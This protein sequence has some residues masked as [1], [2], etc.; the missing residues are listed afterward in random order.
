MP[1]RRAARALA[2]TNQETLERARD[3]S[4][5]L[6]R[7]DALVAQAAS[8]FQQCPKSR[9]PCRS[10]AYL[11]YVTR[12]CLDRRPAVGVRVDVRTDDDH[13]RCPFV[14]QLR[15]DRRRT[16]LN[17]GRA[18][19]LS[20][21]LGDPRKGDERQNPSRSFDDRRLTS[22]SVVATGNPR[23]GVGR[24]YSGDVNDD[25]EAVHNPARIDDTARTEP[26]GLV[27]GSL[28][29]FLGRLNTHV[30]PLDHAR[31]QHAALRDVAAVPLI[32]EGSA[33]RAEPR[34]RALAHVT[35]ALGHS[36]ASRA[37]W[38]IEAGT[39]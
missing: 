1:S 8:P 4:A 35:P 37:P 38:D 36:R 6:D 11:K 18:T 3:M 25:I 26:H 33:P 28:T 16:G 24:P 5:V 31:K 20:A 27:G 14:S 15:T 10:L 9:H 22:Q 19:L 23:R 29:S 32:L 34:S 21:H 7:P 12:R 17:W 39:P 2:S 13:L 30:P